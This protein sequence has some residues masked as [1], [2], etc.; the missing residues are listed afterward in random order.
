VPIAEPASQAAAPAARGAAR[1]RRA[2]LRR[3][4]WLVAAIPVAAA[5]AVGGYRLGGASLWRDEAYTL[6]AAGRPSGQ[7]VGLLLHVDAVHGPYYLGMH[8]VIGLLGSSAAALRLPSLLATSLAAGLTAVLGRR[9]ARMSSLPVPALTGMLAGLLYVA[10]PQTTWYAQD[11]RPYGLVTLFAVAA[12]YLLVVAIGD[13]RRRW[14]AA[15]R[16][17]WR[18]A[19][20]ASSAARWTPGSG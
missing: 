20:R 19:A 18:S 10:A 16:C 5:L 2:A 3:P 9:L 8:L 1:S 17:C 4:G 12:S 7:I 6:A 15:S 14:W 11:A 13:G